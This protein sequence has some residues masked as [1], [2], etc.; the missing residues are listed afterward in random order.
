MA[1]DLIEWQDVRVIGCR[2]GS[3]SHPIPGWH[4]PFVYYPK[5]DFCFLVRDVRT[6][7]PIVNSRS[8]LQELRAAWPF[9]P[10]KEQPARR[11]HLIIIRPLGDYDAELLKSPYLSTNW[12]ATSVPHI[13]YQYVRWFY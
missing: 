8:T 6:E 5:G 11:N 1:G 12:G 9:F 10:L 3:K 7:R 13:V 2:L 4:C